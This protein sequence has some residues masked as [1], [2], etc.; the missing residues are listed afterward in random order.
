MKLRDCEKIIKKQQQH[1]FKIITN[2]TEQ[3]L[4]YCT[5][6]DTTPELKKK[7]PISLSPGRGNLILDPLS[8]KSTARISANC[9]LI[10]TQHITSS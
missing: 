4:F 8:L 6:P 9:N 2:N 5:L 7:T 3:S 1:N 10:L